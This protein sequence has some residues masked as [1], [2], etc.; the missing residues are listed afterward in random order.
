[1]ARGDSEPALSHLPT[2]IC[3][4]LAVHEAPPDQSQGNVLELGERVHFADVVTARELRDVP[5]QVLRAQ[6]VIDGGRA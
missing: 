3:H 1:M 4:Q 5:L 6:L 2:T